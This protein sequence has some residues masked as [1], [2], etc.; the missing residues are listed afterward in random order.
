MSWTETLN[1]SSVNEDWTT[2]AAGLR[3]RDGD[4]VLCVTGS[5]DRVLDLLA[6]A[7]VRVVGIDCAAPQNH[8]LRLTMAAMRGLPW[9]AYAAFM[10]LAD[11]EPGWREAT[12]AALRLPADT[13]AFWVAHRRLVRRGVLS[14][15][16]FERWFRA[17][18]R[19]ARLAHPGLVEALFACEDLETQRIVVRERWERPAWRTTFSLAVSPVTSRV[20]YGDPGWYAHVGV[21]PGPWLF[22]R[23]TAGLLRCLAR[24]SFM[25]SLVL[26]GRLSPWALPPFLTPEG[27]AVIRER[28]DRIE[29]VDAE[30]GAWLG[31]TSRHF[32]RFSLSDVPSYQTAAEFHALVGLLGV[33]ARPHARVVIRQF[34]TQ[35]DVPEGIRREPELEARLAVEDRAFAYSFVVGEVA[36]A[37]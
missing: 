9:S 27:F 35:Y 23:F 32:D 13:A 21:D 5:G 26:R 14:Q 25:A 36:D 15:G 22:E 30:I 10:G 17:L 20:L 2:E 24:D 31:A 6:A 4:E 37:R 29:V 16:R 7:D 1:Y 34:L 28:L 12:L 33:H 18:S 11:E 3:L 8:L 19:A